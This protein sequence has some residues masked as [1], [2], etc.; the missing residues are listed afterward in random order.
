MTNS[1]ERDRPNALKRTEKCI[2]LVSLLV[3]GWVVGTPS[4]ANPEEG[5]FALGSSFTYQGQLQDQGAAAQGIYDISF[6]LYTE[7]SGGSSIGRA[8]LF[9]V[10]VENGIFTVELDFGRNVFGDAAAFVE[11]HVREKGHSANPYLALH[12]RQRL[13]GIG[14]LCTINQDVR[15]NGALRVDPPGAS[16]TALT[17]A[18]CNDVDDGGQ[19]SIGGSLSTLLLDANELQAVDV[20]GTGS[21]ALNPEGGNVGINV[22]EA[23]APLSIPGAPDVSPTGGG[24]LVLG[25]L[26]SQNVGLDNNEIMSRV[27]GQ[28]SRLFLN[29]EGGRVRAGGDLDIGVE[30]VSSTAALHRVVVIC[31]AG[32]SI[33]SGGCRNNDGDYLT[34]TFPTTNT[35]TCGFDD[36]DASN[37]AYAICARI[38]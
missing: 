6:D 5:A 26:S 30:Q 13:A 22:D 2:A 14:S 7:R 36:N 24:A 33:L 18:C 25:S 9:D 28:T 23:T 32:K 37:T 17:V 12:P 1:R 19:A 21:F 10:V 27:S 4:W 15:V 34:E 8:D 35:W 29:N 16:D 31:P 3:V 20:T 11:I 38:K